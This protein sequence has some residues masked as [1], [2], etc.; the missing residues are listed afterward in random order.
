MGRVKDCS[1]SCSH[2]LSAAAAVLL[3]LV[4]VIAGLIMYGRVQVLPLLL[5]M[6]GRRKERGGLADPRSPLISSTLPDCPDCEV[7]L[8]A[9]VVA[10]VFGLTLPPAAADPGL[11]GFPVSIPAVVMIAVVLMQRLWMRLPSSTMPTLTLM[12]VSSL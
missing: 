3:S 5:L 9:V 1:F 7:L 8:V 4:Q 11:R 2:D 6:T 12:P 10:A